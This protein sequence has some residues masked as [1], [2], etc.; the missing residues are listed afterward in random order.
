MDALTKVREHR[1]SDAANVV[2]K[3]Q[4]DHT[5]DRSDA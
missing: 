3:Q 2:I 1:K 4:I 5:D